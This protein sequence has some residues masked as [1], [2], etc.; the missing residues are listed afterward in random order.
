MITK[1][2]MNSFHPLTYEGEINVDDAASID[3][4]MSLET[5]IEVRTNTEEDICYGARKRAHGVEAMERRLVPLVLMEDGIEEANRCE[6]R[7]FRNKNV[8]DE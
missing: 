1:N 6:F 2:K 3:E 8:D 7:E 4:Q 5:Q